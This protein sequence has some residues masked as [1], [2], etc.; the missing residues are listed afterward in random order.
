MCVCVCVGRKDCSSY[1]RSPGVFPG[2]VA[3]LVGGFGRVARQGL[4]YAALVLQT[5][6]DIAVVG[7][8]GDDLILPSHG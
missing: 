6:P 8:L 5:A 2:I 4:L 1:Q 7:M 3:P